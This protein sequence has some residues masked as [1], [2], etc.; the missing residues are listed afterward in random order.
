MA[1]EIEAIYKKGVLKPLKKLDLKEGEKV[2]VKIEKESLYEIIKFY[3][4]RFKLKEKEI[5]EFLKVR[6]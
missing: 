1:I 6:R 5:E 4:K 2:K 3:Q